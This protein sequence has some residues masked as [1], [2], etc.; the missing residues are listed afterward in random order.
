MFYVLWAVQEWVVRKGPETPSIFLS[1][2]LLIFPGILQADKWTQ[3]TQMPFWSLW[4]EVGYFLPLTTAGT[5]W[6][7]SHLKGLFPSSSLLLHLF[8]YLKRDN[9]PSP[10]KYSSLR[11]MFVWRCSAQY[12]CDSVFQMSPCISG[13]NWAFY[14]SI[15]LYQKS[16]HW[17]T[18]NANYIGKKKKGIWH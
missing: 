1:P 4:K 5:H 7:C 15:V 10:L 17:L 11:G 9:I 3:N 2:Q 6:E 8:W 14:Y 16:P 12:F 13:W 18:K